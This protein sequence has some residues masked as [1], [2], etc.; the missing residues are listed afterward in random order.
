MNSIFEPVRARPRPPY[1]DGK[2]GLSFDI[3]KREDGTIFVH[4]DKTAALDHYVT[5][6]SIP[7]SGKPITI[8][9]QEEWKPGKRYEFEAPDHHWIGPLAREILENHS[10]NQDTAKMLSGRIDMEVKACREKRI[11]RVVKDEGGWLRMAERRN[12]NSAAGGRS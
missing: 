2:Y 5:D 7:A 6:V 10:L 3:S 11:G 9:H 4:R 12:A 8:T 1:S